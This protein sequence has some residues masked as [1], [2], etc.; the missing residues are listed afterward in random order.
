MTVHQPGED[1]GEVGGWIDVVEF[2]VLHQGGQHRPVMG[3]LVGAGEERVLPIEGYG[4]HGSLDRV[5]VEL[6]AAVAE[7]DG[8]T[9]PVGERVADL[10]PAFFNEIGAKQ[11]PVPFRA[12]PIA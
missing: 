12:W 5:G 10:N 6:D 11:P 1:V 4:A 9:L 2:A 8:E 3:A 7:E